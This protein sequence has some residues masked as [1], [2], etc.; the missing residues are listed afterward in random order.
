MSDS[1]FEFLEDK[2]IRVHL[3]RAFHLIIELVALSEAKEYTP[4]LKSSFRKTIIIYTASIIE[5]LLLSML[6]SVKT[7]DECGEDKEIVEQILYKIN[8]EEKI[9]LVK[10]K[11][12]SINFLKLNLDQTN[13]LCKKFKLISKDLSAKIDMV[14][15]LRNRQ[16]LGSLSE[17]EITYTRK[18]L[19]FVFSVA[20]EVTN[21]A[22]SLTFT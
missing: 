9:A 2:I 3:D 12:V 1:R 8:D 15:D 7:E 20:K 17:I 5:A 11:S 22:Q 14:R 16:H 21:K 18:D 13:K 6:K 4:E 19:E 10:I